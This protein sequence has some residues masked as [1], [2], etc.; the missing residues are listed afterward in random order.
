MSIDIIKDKI[1]DPEESFLLALISEQNI[2]NNFNN[3]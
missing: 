2:W 1:K 3:N